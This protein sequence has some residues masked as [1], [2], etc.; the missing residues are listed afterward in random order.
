AGSC[1]GRRSSPTIARFQSRRQADPR[2]EVSKPRIL[3]NGIKHLVDI[4]RREVARA[5]LAGFLQNFEGLVV[6]AKSQV[7]AQDRHAA[8]VL[9]FL[10]APL[11]LGEDV[12]GLLS[13]PGLSAGPREKSKQ[14]RRPA[15]SADLALEDRHRP[16]RVAG[17]ERY[18]GE[19]GDGRR[20]ARL[21]LERGLDL[22]DSGVIAAG[23]AEAPTEVRIDNGRERIQRERPAKFRRRLLETAKK[24]QSDA[25]E[26][27]RAGH[28]RIEAN[29]SPKPLFGAA[30]IPLPEQRIRKRR[31]RF[32]QR[33]VDLDGLAS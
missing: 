15:N 1:C 21:D 25:E 9:P 6:F 18:E 3:A 11:E 10:L 26:M 4:E 5:V 20:E 13:I 32:R 31:M 30:E 27:M 14:K 29:R 23:T 28:A 19:P 24:G 17:R 16:W 33:L 2:H 22:M 12:S 7:P 8:D